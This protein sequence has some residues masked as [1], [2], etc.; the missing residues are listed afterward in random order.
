MLGGRYHSAV[1]IIEPRT[2]EGTLEKLITWW[3]HLHGSA[4]ERAI[5]FAI[6]NVAAGTFL[7]IAMLLVYVLFLAALFAFAKIVERYY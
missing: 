1:P 5:Q 7:L 2:G 6:G 3:C 4:D